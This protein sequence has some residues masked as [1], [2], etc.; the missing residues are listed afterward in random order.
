MS[1]YTEFW[2]ISSPSKRDAA[3]A[4]VASSA[5]NVGR[6]IL[7]RVA[8]IFERLI[9]A[10]NGKISTGAKQAISSELLDA[11]DWVNKGDG[12][13]KVSKEKEHAEAENVGVSLLIC[14]TGMRDGSDLDSSDD[15]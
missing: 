8:L 9:N 6:Q 3:V 4:T 15:H 10:A 1:S 13:H 14:F 7:D 12:Q 2:L 11:D 5:S